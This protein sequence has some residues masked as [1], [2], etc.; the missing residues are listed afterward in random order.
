MLLYQKQKFK[1]DIKSIENNLSSSTVSLVSK[2]SSKT[3]NI[4]LSL[5]CFSTVEK[6]ETIKKFKANTKIIEDIHSS[7]T[8]P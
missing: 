8:L 4:F 5:C 2:T 7:S 3:V 6:A 1:A